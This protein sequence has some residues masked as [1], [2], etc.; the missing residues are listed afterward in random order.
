MYDY[1]NE[2]KFLTF[3]CEFG[4]FLHF[5]SY[6]TTYIKVDITTIIIVAFRGFFTV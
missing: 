6:I 2:Y 1:Y 5:C 3:K 4:H